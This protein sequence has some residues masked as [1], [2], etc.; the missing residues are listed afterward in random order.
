MGY[1]GYSMSERAVQAY[2]SGLVPASKT[3]VPAKLVEQYCRYSEWHHT[4]GRY[5]KT[6]FYDRHHVRVIFDLDEPNEDDE[7]E[8]ILPNPGAIEALANYNGHSEQV[9]ENAT[10]TWL[11]W[12]GTRAHPR[13]TECKAEGCTVLIKGNTARVTFAD[14]HTMTKRLTTTG[15]EI[16]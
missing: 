1:N 7:E 12:G 15:F 2:T 11:E 9:I 3:G 10:V 16:N 8:E 4:S 14:G 6:K 13:A 5:N